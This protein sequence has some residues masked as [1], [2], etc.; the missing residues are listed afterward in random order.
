DGQLPGGVGQLDIGGIVYLGQA[1]A[2]H[3]NFPNL[4]GGLC[5]LLPQENAGPLLWRYR[6]PRQNPE[7]LMH[8]LRP[9]CP[10]RGIVLLDQV[11]DIID[12]SAGDFAVTDRA[13]D[14]AL[15]TLLTVPEHGVKAIVTTRVTPRALL[16][17]RP[18][19]QRVL[20]LSEGLG[21]PYAEE[22]LRARD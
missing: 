18:E 10:R 22:V 8:A 19:R 17:L 4:F 16:R 3:V 7:T 11:E 15:R 9:V 20:D 21:S 14:E 12:P 6:D 13:L 2:H 1:G 5:R